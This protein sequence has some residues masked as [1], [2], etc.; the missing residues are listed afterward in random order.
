M[1]KEIDIKKT[2]RIHSLNLMNSCKISG[3]IFFNSN[4]ISSEISRESM[5]FLILFLSIFAFVRVNSFNAS[6][7]FG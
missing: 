4:F 5:N 7:G 1:K 2:S 6:Y 3:V